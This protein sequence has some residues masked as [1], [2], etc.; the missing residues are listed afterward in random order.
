MSR[1]ILA[2]NE[3][4]AEQVVLVRLVLQVVR[5]KLAVQGALVPPIMLAL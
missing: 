4:L 3:Q 2:I 1:V 5:V